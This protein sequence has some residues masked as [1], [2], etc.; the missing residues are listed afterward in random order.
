[1]DKLILILGAL[2]GALAGISIVLRNK[3]NKLRKAYNEL[4]KDKGD[5]YTLYVQKQKAI[6]LLEIELKEIKR[7]ND[8]LTVQNSSLRL[9]NEGHLMRLSE[10][11]NSKQAPSLEGKNKDVL[12]PVIRGGK[13]KKPRN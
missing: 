1:M 7:K 3:L 12:K 5:L 9:Q 8:D 2:A 11:D 13:G 6:I 10:K 4:V